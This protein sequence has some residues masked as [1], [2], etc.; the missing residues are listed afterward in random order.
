MPSR[1]PIRGRD[2]LVPNVKKKRMLVI[3]PVNV[4]HRQKQR[5]SGMLQSK[6]FFGRALLAGIAQSEFVL[7]SLGEIQKRAQT[8]HF[9]ANGS[10]TSPQAP[11]DTCETG[12]TGPHPSKLCSRCRTRRT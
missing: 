11:N 9:R 4:N 3:T 12:K 8:N 2:S 5:V 7:E 6:P 10:G 1:R